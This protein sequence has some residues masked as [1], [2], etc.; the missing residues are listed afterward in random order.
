MHGINVLLAKRWVH[1]C[2]RWASQS[3]MCGP[4]P[5]LP[6]QLLAPMLE[7]MWI[8]LHHLSY[9]T[10][11]DLKKCLHTV[12]VMLAKLEMAHD[13]VRRGKVRSKQLQLVYR[14]ECNALY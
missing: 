13:N 1:R 7:Q 14:I 10:N 11:S 3:L 8:A 2:Q 5:V 9:K 4:M 6:Q 12:A